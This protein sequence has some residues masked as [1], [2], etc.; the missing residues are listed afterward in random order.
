MYNIIIGNLRDKMKEGL[1][2]LKPYEIRVDRGN[3]I[4]GN[5]FIMR[6]ESERDSV[7]NEYQEWFD[8]QIANKDEEV[9]KELR[10]I[11]KIWKEHKTIYLYCWC[12]PKRCHA[13]TIK[14]FLLKFIPKEN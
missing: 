4:L 9:L 10:R 1:N 14:N 6:N 7:C 11:W 8:R 2:N 5:R 3:K 12:A 13:E